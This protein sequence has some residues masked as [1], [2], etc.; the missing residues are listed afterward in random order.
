MCLLSLGPPFS[1]GQNLDLIQS[2]KTTKFPLVGAL[3]SSGSELLFGL[4]SE[5]QT[6]AN[7]ENSV[8]HFF[9]L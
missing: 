5:Q 2:E 3:K 6:L 4:N 8:S 1:L 7:L 9:G